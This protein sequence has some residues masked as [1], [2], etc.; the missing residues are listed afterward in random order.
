MVNIAA[1]AAT[2]SHHLK[3][4]RLPLVQPRNA[5]E[6]YVLAFLNQHFNVKSDYMTNIILHFTDGDLVL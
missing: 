6:R 3:T 2:L 4:W 1:L 5:G